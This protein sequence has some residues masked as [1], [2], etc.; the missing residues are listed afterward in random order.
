[1]VGILKGKNSQRP[2]ASEATLNKFF[3]ATD[4]PRNTKIGV[5]ISAKEYAWF[6]VG[7]SVIDAENVIYDGSLWATPVTNVD[8]AL[9]YLYANIGGGGSDLATTLAAGN[10]TGTNDIILSDNGSTTLSQKVKDAYT[11][12]SSFNFGKTG[13]VSYAKITGESYISMVAGSGGI[14]ADS[15]AGTLFNSTG[16]FAAV[17]N[18]S[19]NFLLA[20]TGVA[21]WDGSDFELGLDSSINGKISFYNASNSNKVFIRS[22]A[23]A[24][25]YTLVLPTSDSTGTQALVSN[26]S[27]TL[28][29]A[30]IPAGVTPAALTKTDDTNVTL[31][32]GGTPATALLQATSLTLGWTGTLADGRIASAATWN[33]KQ[34]AYAI[35]STLGALADASGVLTNNGAGVLSWA[36]AAT[37]TVTSVGVSSTD[38][39]VSGSPVTTSGSITLNVNTNA[40][41]YAK[42]QQ[43]AA[44]SVVGNGTNALAN[45]S[46]ITGTANQVLR[47]NGAGTLLEFGQVNLSSPN[48][49]TGTLAEGKGGTGNNSYAVGDLLY[50]SGTTTLSKLADV[51]VGSYLRSGGVTTAPLWSTLKLPNTA[52]ATYIVY[53]TSANTLGE[54]GNLVYDG[55][56]FITP[57]ISGSKSSGSNLTLVSTTHATKGKII[58]GSA[59]AYDEVNDALG[60]GTTTPYSGSDSLRIEKTTAAAGRVSMRIKNNTAT[61]FVQWTAEQGAV[62]T[63][64]YQFGGSYS[65]S[66]RFIQS[67]G[68][69]EANY[70]LY[71]SG[72]DATVGEIGFYTRGNNLRMT[73]TD[74]LTFSDAVNIAFNTTTGTKHG[75]ATT[76]KQ[77][78]WNATPIV[79]PVSANQAAVTTTV[80]TT[81]ATNVAPYGY[82][83]A[84][85][86]D[87]LITEV[88]QLKTLVNQLRSDLVAIGLIKGS[89]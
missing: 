77:S 53:A 55:T 20:T 14:T 38:L 34:T 1:M 62:S 43:V 52:T 19:Y 88:G 65:T 18:S 7:S 6:D 83:T 28:S 12:A 42:F 9:D 40:I 71:L 74:T 13:L 24:A 80:A 11:G 49:V 25:S 59:S 39:S 45:A 50:A 63:Y 4:Y 44:L 86:A 67:C 21:S 75:T 73:L 22:G 15:G 16:N 87:D 10:T 84:A 78:F 66:G 27:G 8:E 79:Q 85:Q 17:I 33:A 2:R 48:A 47:V 26:G 72:A 23:T 56:Q 82:T 69:I 64:L 58:L 37:G 3:L 32:L 61:G 46:A 41:T 31:T 76:Q 35:L 57:K 51:A 36:A 81:A 70:K 5:A 29:W 89:A 60:I 68:L 54:S 30:S